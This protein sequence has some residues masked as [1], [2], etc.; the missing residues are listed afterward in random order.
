[1]PQ[2]II[3]EEKLNTFNIPIYYPSPSEVKLEVITEGSFVMNQ[4][5][6]SEINWNA[7]D[8]FESELSESLGDDG[9]NV[10]QCMR[11]LVEP[12]LVSHFGE[13]VVKEVFN[14]Y[15]KY[16]ISRNSKE[17]TRFINITILLT[18]RS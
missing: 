10:A 4:L 9:Y 2:G 18:K 1:M 11:A 14:R 15:K 7:R 12:L 5:E 3:K 8:D 17:R 13:G 16:L 6:I